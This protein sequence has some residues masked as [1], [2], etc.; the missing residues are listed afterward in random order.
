LLEC[1]GAQDPSAPLAEQA[2]FVAHRL[3]FTQDIENASFTRLREV[4]LEWRVP[5]L[6]LSGAHE[7]RLSIA[8]LNLATWTHYR[9]IDPEVT[10]GWFDDE[11]RMDFGKSPIPRTVVVRLDLR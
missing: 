5:N 6:A 10:A 4:A 9:G 1:R 2:A 3:D 11:I 8:G 7:A